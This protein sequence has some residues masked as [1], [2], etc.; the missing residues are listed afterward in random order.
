MYTCHIMEANM[1]TV[2]HLTAF[3]F[4]PN[5]VEYSDVRGLCKS[6][7]AKKPNVWKS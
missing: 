4:I 1:R 3:S 5:E 7:T 6:P 2:W